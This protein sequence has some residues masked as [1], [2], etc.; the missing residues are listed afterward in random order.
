MVCILLDAF[1]RT[2][3][4]RYAD[5]HPFL[6][7]LL[8]DGALVEL[9]TQFPSTTTAHVTTMHTGLPVGRHGLYEWNVYE[10]ALDAVITPLKFSYAGGGEI[11]ALTPDELLPLPTFYEQLDVPS[12]VFQPA[13]FSPSTFDSAALRGSTVL[14]YDDLAHA[15]RDAVDAV[16]GPAGGYA[17]VYYDRIDTAGHVYGPSA[18]E[19]DV[20]VRWA[21]DG[22]A[23]GLRAATPG[24]RTRLLLTADHGQVD[25][26]P[27]A[28]LWLDD[29]WP[30]LRDLLALRPA[31]SARDVFLHVP[32][33]AV[34]DA[35]AGLRS[36]LGDAADVRAVAELVA[37]GA[38]GPAPGPRLLERLGSVCVLPAPGSMAW[39]RS[40]ADLQE[41]FRGHHGGRTPEEST[42]YLATLPLTP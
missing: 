35:V 10:P 32:D 37:E 41:H 17:Y 30:P 25:V 13:A 15:V 4:D 2:F 38:F 5:D 28:M 31:G 3:L 36:V 6:R 12:F 34:A 18:P 26:D 1:G 33:A 29:L 23:A 11:E 8:A 40:A 22:V 42:T 19:F 20:G 21:L 14:P 24:P 7:R 39:L 9:A 27:A 16:A